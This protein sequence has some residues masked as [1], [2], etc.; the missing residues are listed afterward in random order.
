[1][2]ASRSGFREEDIL[3]I[4]IL[5]V[6]Y[7]ICRVFE[8]GYDHNNIVTL[9][10]AV[11]ALECFLTDKLEN[12]TYKKERDEIDGLNMKD[13]FTIIQDSEKDIKKGYKIYGNIIKKYKLLI[14]LSKKTHVAK[15]SMDF[16]FD[17][18]RK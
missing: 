3:R 2:L 16:A 13:I 9:H 14:R 1:M 5:W 15:P 6:G 8:R 12:D 7:A 11:E 10:C 4:H 18:E 17:R